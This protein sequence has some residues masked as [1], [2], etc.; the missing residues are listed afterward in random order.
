[1]RPMQSKKDIQKHQRTES[2]DSF[3]HPGDELSR[4][5]LTASFA[6]FFTA[7][8]KGVCDAP[9]AVEHDAE[10]GLANVKPCGDGLEYG[11]TKD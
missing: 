6:A 5:L 3:D 11:Q 9:G 2:Q 7:A 4:D 1:M 8:S 10:L